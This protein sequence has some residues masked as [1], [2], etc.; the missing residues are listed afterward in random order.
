METYIGTNNTRPC[1]Q[2][3]IYLGNNQEVVD[4]GTTISQIDL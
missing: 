4:N 1:I 3:G 2:V